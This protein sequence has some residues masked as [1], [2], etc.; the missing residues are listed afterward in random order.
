MM[1]I[2]VVMFPAA[3]CHWGLSIRVLIVKLQDTIQGRAAL[4]SLHRMELVGTNLLPGVNVSLLTVS[5]A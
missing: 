2:T 1:M 5:V 4:S 3:S